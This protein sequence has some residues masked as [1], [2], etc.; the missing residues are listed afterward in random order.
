MWSRPILQSCGCDRKATKRMNRRL[1]DRRLT[2][3]EAH[4]G[5]QPLRGGSW[6]PYR[7][8]WATERKHLPLVDVAGLGGVPVRLWERSCHGR[9]LHNLCAGITALRTCCCLSAFPLRGVRHG[10]FITRWC[11]S[12]PEYEHGNRP[13]APTRRAPARELPV[14][15]CSR[16]QRCRWRSAPRLPSSVSST[17]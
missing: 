9:T 14:S 2:E 1:L 12:Q 6:H 15:R 5:L 13:G 8:K 3:A 16:W 4:A 10:S 11:L 17:A 7:R